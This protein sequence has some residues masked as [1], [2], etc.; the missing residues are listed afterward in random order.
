MSFNLGNIT[1][2]AYPRLND[3]LIAVMVATPLYF[4]APIFLR[5]RISDR[6]GNTLP[7]GPPIRYAF[8]RNYPER[9]LDYWAKKYGP[10]FSIWMGSQLFVVISDPQI[11]RDLLV[12]QGA[13]FSSRKRYF[14]K[15]QVILRG[16]AITASEYGDKWRQHRRIVA[17]VLAP[18]AM[19]G[20]ASIMEYESHILIKS[21]YEEGQK[22]KLPINPAH[23]AGRFALNNMLIISFGMRT[24]SS[25]DPLV[26]KALILA[27][28][29]MDLTGPWSN[30]VDFFEPL[31]WIPT[32]K[33]SRGHKVHDGL[34]NVYGSMIRRFQSRMDSGG[35]VPDF[36]VKT[37]IQCR[38]EEGLDW[39]DICMLAAVF[40]LGGVPSTSGIIQWFLALIPSHPDIAAKAYEELDR[41]VGRERWPNIDD[42]F[43]LP[44][45]RAIIKEVQRVHAPFWMATPH[46]TSQDF[47]YKGNFIP[48]DTAVVLNCYTLHHNEE[49]YPDPFTFKP[50]RYL[51]DDLSCAE[52]A[53]LGNAMDRDHWT[54]G[55]GRRICPGLPAA[56]RELWLAISRLLWAYTF[57]AL[58]DEPI[59]LEEYDGKSGRTPRAYRLRLVPRLETLSLILKQADEVKISW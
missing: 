10:L 42:E 2:L 4:L 35:E 34:I 50:E 56:E 36:L 31:Q 39:E 37:L 48:K 25:S 51:G 45:I 3:F 29:F 26:E 18:K 49:R 1:R 30:V 17:Q 44:Y 23:Y 12:T 8:L 14:M 21:L 47:A 13:T 52:S 43:N 28:E 46:Y 16:R 11:A 41:V 7:P 32:A 15:N 54:F 9:A 22:G 58:P 27:M 59:S 33:R 53:K 57:H 55:A 38:E 19:Q 5:V 20:F 24:D 40:T 6:N